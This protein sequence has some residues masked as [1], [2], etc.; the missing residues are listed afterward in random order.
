MPILPEISDEQFN[1]YK[2]QVESDVKENKVVLYMRG[3]PE[4]PRCGFSAR[5]VAV[6]EDLAAKY[7]SVDLDSDP[8]LWKALTKIN[9][10]PTS[11]QIFVNGEFIGGCDNA[12]EMWESGDLKKALD[13]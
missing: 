6:F 4:A 9:D 5:T 3:T 7:H 10:W 13:S 12:I 11:P 8:G 1:Q 2:S